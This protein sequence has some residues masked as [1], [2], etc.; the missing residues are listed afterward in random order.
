MT[1]LL[2]CDTPAQWFIFLPVEA[3]FFQDPKFPWVS[4][5]PV[6]HGALWLDASPYAAYSVLCQFP[7]L[8]LP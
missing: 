2:H 3:N 8:H 5:P 4:F 6:Y 1:R 7:L